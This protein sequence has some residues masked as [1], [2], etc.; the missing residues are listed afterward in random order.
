MNEQ[1]T[2]IHRVTYQAPVEGGGTRKATVMLRNL[3]VREHTM[4]G[5]AGHVINGAEVDKD[6]DVTDRVQVI[7]AGADDFKIT[8]MVTDLMY[9]TLVVRESAASKRIRAGL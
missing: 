9:G 2:G 1:M 4:A 3:T 8:R 6:G 5:E 7:F